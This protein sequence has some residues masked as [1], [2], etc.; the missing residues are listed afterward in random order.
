M[1]VSVVV[2]IRT[3]KPILIGFEYRSIE[4]VAVK[5][6]VDNMSNKTM[7]YYYKS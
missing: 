3:I 2:A 6:R 1:D 7:F 5:K 4:K